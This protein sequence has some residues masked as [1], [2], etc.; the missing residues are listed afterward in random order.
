MRNYAVLSRIFLKS[1]LAAVRH[2]KAWASSSSVR[3]VACV[4]EAL[5]DYSSRSNLKSYSQPCCI[6]ALQHLFSTSVAPQPQRAAPQPGIS[7]RRTLIALLACAATA[8]QPSTRPHRRNRVARPSSADGDI[9]RPGRGNELAGAKIAQ[10]K[11]E[12]DEAQK[13]GDI[14][15][16]S[17]SS[18]ARCCRSKERTE[19]RLATTPSVVRAGCASATKF[20]RRSRGAVP[21]LDRARKLAPRSKNRALPFA[22]TATRRPR[23]VLLA[24]CKTLGI[25]QAPRGI[26]SI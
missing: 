14:D 24:A 1:Q 19:R 16:S 6:R 4:L 11:K 15:T 13:A 9:A 18:W 21:G 22:A 5:F 20:R 26:R 12:M 10:L 8:P 3:R 2:A 25:P 23:R 7:M 17:S